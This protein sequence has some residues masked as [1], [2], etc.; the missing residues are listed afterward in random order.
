MLLENKKKL[1]TPFNCGHY[2]LF[3]LKLSFMECDVQM[4]NTLN[5][6]TEDKKQ[7]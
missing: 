6:M 2:T 1:S 3:L 7:K 5:I 4:G